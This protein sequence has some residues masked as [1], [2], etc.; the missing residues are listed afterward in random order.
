MSN[1]ESIRRRI[2][3]VDLLRG[4]VMM[5]MLLDHT[6]EFVHWAG[7]QFDPTDLS[8][9]YPILFFTRWITHFCAPTFVFLSGVSIY[10][11]RLN[12]KTNAELSRLLWTRG[13]WLIVLEFTI[14]RFGFSFNLDYSFFGAAQVIW[15]IGVSMIVMAGLI[16]APVKWVGVAG[17]AMIV[18]H[19]LLDANR[20]PPQVAFGG[21]TPIGS[22]QALWMILHQQG[23]ISL[24]GSSQVLILYPLIPW[25]GV[26]AAGWAF[27]SIYSLEAAQRRKIGRAHV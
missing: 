1:D 4:V 8:R 11:Q 17:V 25:I 16:Y 24:I 26:M 12:G 19:N 10:L 7:L 6:R 20:I 2:L 13:L 23:F 15:V 21:Q 9:T 14:V 5:I 18:L 3:A 27:G 22:W